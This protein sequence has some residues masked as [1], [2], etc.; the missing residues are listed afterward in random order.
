MADTAIVD[1]A[2]KLDGWLSLFSKFASFG[3]MGL[4][5]SF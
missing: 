1:K 5:I 3:I 2:D 4:S